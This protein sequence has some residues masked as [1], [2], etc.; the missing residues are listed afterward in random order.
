[1]KSFLPKDNLFGKDTDRINLNK[2]LTSWVSSIGYGKQIENQ[3]RSVYMLSR[4]TDTFLKSNNKIIKQPVRTQNLQKPKLR[5]SQFLWL[6]E[7]FWLD[8]PKQQNIYRRSYF[9][10]VRAC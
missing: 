8:F 2:K 5:A 9:V 10:I 1:M 4:E 3:V 6:D 7:Q